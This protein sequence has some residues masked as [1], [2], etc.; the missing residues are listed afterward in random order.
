ML[1]YNLRYIY[2]PQTNKYI[3]PLTYD[4]EDIKGDENYS[5]LFVSKLMLKG[6]GQCHSMPLLHKILSDEFKGESYLAYAPSH[7]YIRFKDDRGRFINFETTNGSLTTNN[8]V[9]GSGYIKSEAILNKIYT[10][11]VATKELIAQ[12][13]SELATMHQYQLG[14]DDFIDKCTSK[15]LQ[16]Y[17]NSISARMEKSNFESAKLDKAL[18]NINYPPYEKLKEYPKEFKQLNFV[19]MI[20]NDINSLGYSKMPKEAYDKWLNSLAEERQ[21]QENEKLRI[22]L[23]FNKYE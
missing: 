15:T 9:V 22:Q 5:Q 23:N 3:P 11:E 13:L 8:F 20:Y 14:Y 17:P 12:L 1:L 18:F 21:K 16:H 2:D 19:S 6:T 10:K 7:S 4:F